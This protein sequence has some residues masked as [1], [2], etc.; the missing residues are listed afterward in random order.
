MLLDLM[1]GAAKSSC[2]L[3]GSVLDQGILKTNVQTSHLGFWFHHTFWF[4]STGVGP[5]SLHFERAPRCQ[6]RSDDHTRGSKAPEDQTPPEATPAQC[7]GKGACQQKRGWENRPDH[8][9]NHPFSLYLKEVKEGKETENWRQG[10]Y[11]QSWKGD[12]SFLRRSESSP[13]QSN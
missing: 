8:R 5:G 6:W 13:I 9:A 10:N 12:A 7:W 2:F 11:L 3:Q 1:E 4:R